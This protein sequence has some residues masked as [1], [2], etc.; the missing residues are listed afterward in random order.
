MNWDDFYRV[1]PELFISHAAC[2]MIAD[3]MIKSCDC[4]RYFD[5]GV[6]L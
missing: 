1:F 2:S 5:Y 3:D 6:G 4:Q